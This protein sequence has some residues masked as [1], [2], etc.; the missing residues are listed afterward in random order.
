MNLLV[1]GMHGLGDCLHQR[2]IVRQLMNH[3][4]VWLETP[5]PQVYHDM[6]ALHLMSKGSSL[7]TQAKNAARNA[8]LFNARTA[9]AGS[10]HLKVWYAPQVVRQCGSV[11]GAMAATCGVAVDDFSLPVP[12]DWLQESEQHVK[13]DKPILFYRPLVERKEWGGCASRNPDHAAYAEILARVRPGF[14]VVS[15]ADLEDGKEWLAGKGGD[16]DSVLHA[17]ELTFEAMA[18]LMK[19]AA[20]AL[21]APGFATVL[22]QAV[23]TRSITVFGGYEDAR[24]F[25]A[26]AQL[27]PSLFIEPEKP[28]A[29]F[30]HRHACDKRIDLRKAGQHI[31][32]FLC[33]ANE[34][35]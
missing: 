5:W 18:G 3:D 13:T 1:T 32:E 21:T 16:A 23:G 14:H 28:C 4:E 29:C 22:A 15:I 10:R 12:A 34:N 24:S 2:A 31:Q 8:Q 17:G 11:L 33:S 20:L 19:R 9:P 26:G 27:T 35:R 6:P 30:S 7:R 25:S